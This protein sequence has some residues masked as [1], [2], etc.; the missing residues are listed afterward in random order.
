[1]D[2]PNF[3]V[4]IGRCLWQQDAKREAYSFY[5]SDDII[6]ETPAW[7]EHMGGTKRIKAYTTEAFY[8]PSLSEDQFKDLQNALDHDLSPNISLLLVITSQILH[9]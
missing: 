1:M 2:S 9:F 8:L 4:S 3:Y 5:Q 6:C 7:F